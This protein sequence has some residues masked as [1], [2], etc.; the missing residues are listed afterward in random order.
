MWQYTWLLR[1]SI[2]GRMDE[3]LPSVTERNHAFA[4]YN[5]SR[6]RRAKGP[7]ANRRRDLVKGSDKVRDLLCVEP[8]RKEVR[9]D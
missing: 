2:E 9:V 1:A 7:I 8:S 4:S 3:S 6:H 5:K